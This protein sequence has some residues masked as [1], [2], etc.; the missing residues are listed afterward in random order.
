[1]VT[2]FAFAGLTHRAALIAGDDGIAV[3]IMIPAYLLRVPI[4][5][6]SASAFKRAMSMPS[7]RDCSQ[8]IDLLWR[9][10]RM[11]E[12]ILLA[13]DSEVQDIYESCFLREGNMLRILNGLLYDYLEE[14]DLK[15][16]QKPAVIDRK[17]SWLEKMRS[18]VSTA[19]GILGV[20]PLLIP[21]VRALVRDGLVNSGAPEDRWW[22]EAVADAVAVACM[23]TVSLLSSYTMGKLSR[24]RD[25]QTRFQLKAPQDKV[26]S[27]RH[28]ATAVT[29]SAYGK[30]IL[31]SVSGALKYPGGVIAIMSSISLFNDVLG[32]E[33]AETTQDQRMAI[34]ILTRKL[35]EAI[36]Q[37]PETEVRDLHTAVKQVSKPC[38][39]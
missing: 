27:V 33:P 14:G 35:W 28:L 36:R 3:A 19:I 16:L 22:V 32:K 26:K 37:L 29:V 39:R 31:D 2:G 8:R 11:Q 34:Y 6:F 1:M 25:D 21:P 38:Y 15:D 4:I 12:K 30:E 23:S 20:A 17:A 5:Y 9:L 13:K 10:A 7:A 18:G 24:G